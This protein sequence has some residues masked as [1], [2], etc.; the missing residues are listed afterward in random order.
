MFAIGEPI[1]TKK[2]GNEFVQ[3]P[4]KPNGYGEIAGVYGSG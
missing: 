2:W 1:L 3:G 4:A